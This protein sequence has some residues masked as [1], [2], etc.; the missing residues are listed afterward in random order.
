MTY[1]YE[2][3]FALQSVEPG[4]RIFSPE[5]ILLSSIIGLGIVF[6][7]HWQIIKRDRHFSRRLITFLAVLMLGLEIFRIGWHTYY[8]GFDLRNIR[9]DWCNQVC[10]ALP[11][12]VLLGLKRAYPYIDTL[13]IM[14]GL[15]VLIYPLWVFYDYGG[16]HVMAVQSMISHGLMVLIALSMPFSSDYRPE[17]SKFWKPVLGLCIIAAVALVM[18]RLLGE[19]YLLMRDAQGL[20]VIGDIPFPWYWIVVAPLFLG[21]IRLVTRAAER[22]DDHFLGNG[23]NTVDCEEKAVC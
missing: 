3:Y 12:I 4:N 23:E 11:V 8:Y 1:F 17:A 10:L 19:N 6:V 16:L 5:H 18:S 2:N 14:G 13:A 7:M 21:A 20:P 15:A 22:F 9:F